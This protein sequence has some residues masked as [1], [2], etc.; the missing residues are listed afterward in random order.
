MGMERLGGDMR[1][2]LRD[3]A[4]SNTPWARSGWGER[5][6]ELRLLG[7]PPAREPGALGAASR[8]KPRQDTSLTGVRVLLEVE[9]GSRVTLKKE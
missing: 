3:P 9:E 4:L 5:R 6:Q 7:R 8:S 2:K 1:V